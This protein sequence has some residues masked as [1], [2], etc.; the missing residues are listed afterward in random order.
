MQAYGPSFARIYNLLWGGF[1]QDVAPKLRAFYESTPIGAYNRH[2]LDVC[3]GTG[4][5]ARHFLQAGYHVTGLDLS[6]AMLGYAQENNAEATAQG[7]AAWIH[8]DAVDFHCDG[9]FGLVVSTF[10]ALN[11]LP[12]EAA[13]QACFGCVYRVLEPGGWFIFDLNTR[14]GL[15]R[16]E[17]MTVDERPDYTL[18]NRGIYD[19]ASGKVL[20]RISGYLRMEDGRYERFEELAYNLVLDMFAVQKYLVKTGFTTAYFARAAD[21]TTALLDPESEGRVFFVC[22]KGV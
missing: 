7:R 11:H 6:E 2:L 19:E 8:A 21:L 10:D 3:C 20:S 22:Q 14:N 13:L 12:S 5:L 16:W 1:A 18:M 4:V 9:H 15:H 17:G